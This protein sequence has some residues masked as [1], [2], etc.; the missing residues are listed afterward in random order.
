MIPLSGKVPRRLRRFH[1]KEEKSNEENKQGNEEIKNEG[2]FETTEYEAS[3][4]YYSPEPQEPKKVE[5][6]KPAPEE[7][8]DDEAL[9][10]ELYEQLQI[11][12]ELRRET[13]KMAL[14]EIKKFKDRYMRLPD[15]KEYELIADNIYEQ[16]KEKYKKETGKSSLDLR[17]IE[18][19]KRKDRRERRGRRGRGGKDNEKEEKG[20]EKKVEERK[21][22]ADAPKKS[23]SQKVAAATKGL[24]VEGLFSEAGDDSLQLGELA[25]QGSSDL[26]SDLSSL[27]LDNFDTISQDV[28]TVKNKCPNCN[29]PAEELV[30]CSHCGTGFCAHCALKAEVFG[31]KI[32]YT[33]PS[34]K[35]QVSVKKIKAELK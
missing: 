35:K 25:G 24:S 27:G 23:A 4:F 16:V 2:D 8:V 14:N 21:E 13:A 22:G 10:E 15:D 11:E 12:Q 34:C 5:A 33:C 26:D 3:K 17:E 6:K 20:D 30:F 1:R 19:E 9:A 29:T 18:K 28:R 32:K 31:D 7:T